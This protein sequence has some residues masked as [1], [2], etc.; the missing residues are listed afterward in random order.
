MKQDWNNSRWEY[1][2]KRSN[3][4]F[5]ESRPPEDG[6]DSYSFVCHFNADFTDAIS[7][8]RERAVKSGWATRNKAAVKDD[9]YCATAEE[10][11]LERAGA[12]PKMEVFARDTADDQAVFKAISDYLGMEDSMIKFHNQTTGQMLVEHID[13]F[14]GRPERDNSFKE[15]NMDTNPD[16]YRR[17][18]IM[19]DDWHLGQVWQIGNATFTQWKAGDCITWEWQDMPHATGNLGWEERPMLQITGK[20][21][22]RTRTVLANQSGLSVYI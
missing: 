22:D 17:F 1:L 6:K 13:N 2:K 10:A 15:T 11:D 12:D 19:L 5:D 7:I 14:A 3:W 18:V 16:D 21:T 9:L 20:V 4:H 8:C